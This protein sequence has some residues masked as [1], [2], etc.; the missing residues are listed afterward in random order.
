MT[1]YRHYLERW[2][3]DLGASIGLANAY[4]ALGDLDH[5]ESVLRR[6]LEQHPDSVPVINNLAQTLSDK[7]SNEEAL[8]II[9]RRRRA[10]QHAV[11]ETR[12]LIDSGVRGTAAGAEKSNEAT[13]YEVT[14]A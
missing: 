11:R 3:D 10:V 14:H 8:E 1:A 7:G 12:A 4:Y 5:V 13:Q 2:P 9:E 6:A